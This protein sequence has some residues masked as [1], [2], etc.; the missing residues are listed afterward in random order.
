[1]LE[2]ED[3]FLMDPLGLVGLLGLLGLLD[4]PHP[5]SQKYLRSL[6]NPLYLE[7]PQDPP[8]LQDLL[9]LRNPEIPLYLEN[10]LYPLGQ[11]DPRYRPVHKDPLCPVDP[12]YLVDPMYLAGLMSLQ[13]QLVLLLPLDLERPMF[14]LHLGFRLFLVVQLLL[15][16]LVTRQAPERQPFRPLR[17]NHLYQEYHSCP[18]LQRDLEYRHGLVRQGCQEL[19]FRLVDLKF[20]QVLPDQCYQQG[21]KDRRHLRDRQGRQDQH[22]L[23]GLEDHK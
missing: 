17:W 5:S 21:R 7:H 14:L 22:S 6:E 3:R 11:V 23:E 15:V 10:Q 16:I 1:M 19:L 18:W 9:D 8:D 20:P 12:R 13:V 2:W 4:L